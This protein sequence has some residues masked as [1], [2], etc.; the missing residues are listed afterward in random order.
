MPVEK[1][2]NTRPSYKRLWEEEKLVSQLLRH[3]LNKYSAVPAW[4]ASFCKLMNRSIF[5]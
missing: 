1:E 5:K 3:D 4:L 2:I